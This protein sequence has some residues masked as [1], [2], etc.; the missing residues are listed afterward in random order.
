MKKILLTGF[1]LATLFSCKKD[2][3]K[4]NEFTGPKVSFHNSKVWSSLTLT[5]G[6]VPEKLTLVM[7]TSV[8]NNVLMTGGSEGLHHENSVAVPLHP[9]ATEKTP[10][11][12]ILLD[13]APEGHPPAGVYTT[14]HFD[15]H[16]YMTTPQ[17]VDG[18]TDMAKITTPPGAEYIPVNYV[19]GPPVPKMGTHWIDIT[20]PEFNGGGFTQSFLY[21][22]YDGKVVF[23][24]PM[25]TH[26]FLKNTTSFERSIPQ[27]QKVQATGFYP[28]RM[29]VQKVGSVTKITLDQF[30][31]RQAS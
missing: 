22:S 30:V 10:F 18:Y 11:K 29:T 20:S 24:E 28:T 8:L 15:I 17:E 23:Y 31:Q 26:E 3:A 2:E 4:T 9:K 13:W 19:A 7:D 14:R 1:V 21:G 27:P 16:F 12:Y 25:I 5:K 6:D